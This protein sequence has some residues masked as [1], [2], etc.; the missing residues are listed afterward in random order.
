MLNEASMLVLVDFASRRRTGESLVETK[1]WGT[2]GWHDPE[3]T[4]LCLRVTWAL[5]MSCE[6]AYFGRQMSVVIF[7]W[8]LHPDSE[9]DHG[10]HSGISNTKYLGIHG[11]VYIPMDPWDIN[12]THKELHSRLM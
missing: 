1:A 12:K 11:A 5:S 7:D 9:Q 2:H 4:F 3:A 10:S 8:L 6:D